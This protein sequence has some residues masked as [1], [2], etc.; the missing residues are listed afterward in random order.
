MF[1]VRR[2]RFSCS[3]RSKM[4]RNIE[5]K[6]HAS[7]PVRRRLGRAVGAARDPIPNICKPMS[8][9]LNSSAQERSERGGHA[10]CTAAGRVHTGEAVP[11]VQPR[12]QRDHAARRPAARSRRS[13]AAAGTPGRPC[14]DPKPIDDPGR[15]SG[16]R[17]C[18]R[19]SQPRGA[20]GRAA[21][22]K[23]I[24]RRQHEQRQQRRRHD[25]ADDDGRERPLHLGAGARC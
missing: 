12:E 10:A 3:A 14:R 5:S 18:A 15:R 16:T 19:N 24:Q 21:V 8:H 1:I 25:A 23:A 22:S 13:G 11:M 4:A 7:D 20:N 6:L 2:P 9:E 17:R